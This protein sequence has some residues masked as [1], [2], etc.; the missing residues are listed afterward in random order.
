MLVGGERGT[1]GYVPHAAHPASQIC[2]APR[3]PNGQVTSRRLRARDIREH[4][5]CGLSQE[6]GSVEHE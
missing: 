6:L 2:V 3:Q 5:A 1:D 4:E